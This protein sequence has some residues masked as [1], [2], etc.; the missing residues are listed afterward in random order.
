MKIYAWSPTTPLNRHVTRLVWCNCGPNPIAS[1]NSLMPRLREPAPLA[2]RGA[3]AGFLHGVTE[4]QVH[5][6]PPR[7]EP[8]VQYFSAFFT[9]AK[10][11]GAKIAGLYT[12]IE[13]WIE[14]YNWAIPQPVEE[15]TEINVATAMRRALI[16]PL[17][18]N[19]GEVPACNYGDY[20]PLRWP[21][22]DLNGWE[23]K[24]A[25]KLGGSLAGYSAPILYNWESGTMYAK[26]NWT[27]D[28][29][30]N[31]LI[32]NLNNCRTCDVARLTPWINYPSY[33]GDSPWRKCDGARRWLWTEQLKHLIAMGV[34]LVLYWN[35]APAADADRVYANAAF[36]QLLSHQ[37]TTVP[38]S[39]SLE[40]I[41]YDS[42][43]IATSAIETR[44]A[45][46][47]SHLQAEGATP[48]PTGIPTP[49]S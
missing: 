21:I 13:D 24:P 40:R 2:L 3:M 46:F 48:N 22:V 14:N 18:A 45:D 41:E 9:Q 6:A 49:R 19:F 31:T 1:A 38:T 37:P 44:Y 33:G 27:K 15:Q 39:Q 35:P 16:E 12:D 34:E 42:E 4:E 20:V 8:Y 29:S 36:D 43:T 5:K 26:S 10:Q 23:K 11:I 47:L 32:T 30:W 17:T 28:I 25:G 7:I